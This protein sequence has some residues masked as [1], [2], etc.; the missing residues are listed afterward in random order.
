MNDTP[1]Q[2]PRQRNW[3]PG[4]ITAI[5]V[6]MGAVWIFFSDTLA[7]TLCRSAEALTQI[8][9]IKGWLFI[10]L[11]A[12][13]LY[14]LASRG[15][16]RVEK[17]Q[18]ALRLSEE[19][20]R[21]MFE[22]AT[23]GM[24][25]TDPH[26]GQFQRVNARLSAI[27]GYA[28]AEL[29]GMSF[30]Q[31]THPEDREQSWQAFQQVIQGEVS[32]VREEKRYVRQDGTIVWVSVSATLLLDDARQP[33]VGLAVIDDIT[34]RKR[35]EG[36]LTASYEKLHRSLNGTV[37]ALATTSEM[38]DPY[39]AGHQKRVAQLACAIAGEIGLDSS[40]VKGIEVSGFLHDIGKISIPVEILSRAEKLGESEFNL[41]TG[42]PQVGHDILKSI[43][44]PW[45]VAQVILQHHERLDGSGYP[46]GLTGDEII[47]EA[48]ILAVADV[49]DAM[50]LHRPYR[51]AL[52]VDAAL[53]EITK[54]KNILYDPQAVDA[55]V[56]LFNQ[57]G[58]AF[59]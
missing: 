50:A 12:V 13:L 56:M 42:H 15:M 59:S 16:Q 45:E 2:R 34:E 21:A 14:N 31:I 32:E 8:G 1:N 23:V 30:A 17:S 6:V 57:K 52:G 55:C 4:K 27:T 44:F 38:R 35:A 58:F 22:V 46:H 25:Q 11:T 39:T 9:I 29:I 37:A 49:V 43:E 19:R 51:P 10:L 41:L 53:E 54:N 20:F 18:K 47:F 7:A 5:Y 40:R 24:A 48:K 28:V 36:E 33:L 3:L 26:T